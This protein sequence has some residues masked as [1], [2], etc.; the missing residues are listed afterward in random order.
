MSGL[1]NTG[2]QLVVGAVQW[3]IC[4]LIMLIQKQ[5]SCKFDYL[6]ESELFDL[7]IDISGFQQL[8]Q[9]AIICIYL[10]VCIYVLLEHTNLFTDF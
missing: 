6:E 3:Q 8:H 10:K 9:S 2:K 4:V 5:L 7:V 1:E